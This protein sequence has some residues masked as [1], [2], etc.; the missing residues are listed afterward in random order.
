MAYGV[1]DV[2][3]LGLTEGDTICLPAEAL[4]LFAIPDAGLVIGEALIHLTAEDRGRD[5][6]PVT[7]LLTVYL[8]G[9]TQPE[10]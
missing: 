1:G 8:Q 2:F 9:C 6:G 3:R 10:G 5:K 4:A 7:A